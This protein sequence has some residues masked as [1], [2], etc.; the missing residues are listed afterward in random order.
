MKRVLTLL[1]FFAIIAAGFAQ[2]NLLPNGD[3][4][5]LEPNFWTP[6]GDRSIKLV[7]L[8]TLWDGRA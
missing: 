6:L 5:L 7:P 2:T 1:I 3:L 4:E 8:R